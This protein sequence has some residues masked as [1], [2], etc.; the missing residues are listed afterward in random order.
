MRGFG[1][2]S[3]LERLEVEYLP[4]RKYMKTPTIFGPIKLKENI[5]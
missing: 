4:S 2:W 1:C 5:L 3:V